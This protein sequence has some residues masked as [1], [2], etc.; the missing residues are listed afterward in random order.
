MDCSCSHKTMLSLKFSWMSCLFTCSL[1]LYFSTA[2]ALFNA[3]TLSTQD[4]LATI[5]PFS[6]LPFELLFPLNNQH[7]SPSIL[8]NERFVFGYLCREM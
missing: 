2:S 7:F 6:S 1:P 3:D 8:R 5:G 4:P